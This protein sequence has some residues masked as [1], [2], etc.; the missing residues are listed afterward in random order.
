MQAD[1]FVYSLKPLLSFYGKK[2]NDE[3]YTAWFEKLGWREPQDLRAAIGSCTSEERYFPTPAVLGKYIGMASQQRAGKQGSGKGPLEACQYCQSTGLIHTVKG[4]ASYIFKCPKCKNC[5]ANY[6]IW[7]DRFYPQGYRWEVEY[8][9]FDPEDKVQVAGLQILRD[10]APKIYKQI[11]LKTPEM[12]EAVTNYKPP[13]NN[14]AFSM[15]AA[16]GLPE[17]D[18]VEKEK[19]RQESLKQERE[20]ERELG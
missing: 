12:E 13:V 20:R 9:G 1:E 7:E 5:T 18:P 11:L 6:P 8:I 2:L 4:K 3:Q 14:Y 17:M 10:S 16:L 15:N 19:K